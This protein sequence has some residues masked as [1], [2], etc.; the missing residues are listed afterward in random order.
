MRRFTISRAW[1]ACACALAFAAVAGAQVGRDDPNTGDGEP[2]RIFEGTSTRG[3]L[4]EALNDA[5]AR[6]LRS[7][8]GADRMVRYRVREITGEHGGIAG[9]NTIHVSIEVPGA[10]DARPPAV[11]RPE[12]TPEQ[13]AARIRQAVRANVMLSPVEVDR[14]GMVEMELLARNGSDR[15]VSIPFS[16]GQKFDFEIW[17]DNKL[18]WRWSQGRFFTQSLNSVTLEPGGTQTYRATWNLRTSDNMR[19]PAGRYLVRG[20]LTPRS[21]GLRLGDTAQL[22]ITGP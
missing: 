11:E 3:S 2:L 17:R 12:E 22:T 6:A 13:L 10:E 15:A 9:R 7:L 21:E 19:V 1:I 4:Q 18:V 16:T 5:S 20:Y 8:P 14:A